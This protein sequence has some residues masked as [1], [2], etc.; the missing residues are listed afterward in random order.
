V[1][2][3]ITLAERV[4]GF[5]CPTELHPDGCSCKAVTWPTRQ[6]DPI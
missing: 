6:C 2:E 3:I 5:L 4:N 1:L